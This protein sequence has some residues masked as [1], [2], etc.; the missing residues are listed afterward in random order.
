M[1]GR[2]AAEERGGLVRVRVRVRVRIRVRVRVGVTL[3]LTLTLTLS[4]LT[5]LGDEALEQRLRSD[6]AHGKQRGLPRGDK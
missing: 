5:R 6:L 3:T 4:N 2:A 1:R